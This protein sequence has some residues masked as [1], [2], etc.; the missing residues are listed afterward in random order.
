MFKMIKGRDFLIENGIFL[1][2]QFEKFQDI[3]GQKRNTFVK[4]I[5]NSPKHLVLL[6]EKLGHKSNFEYS[7][8]FIKNRK[9]S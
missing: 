7:F 1:N 6:F 3:K 5:A 9:I 4:D 8:P 2:M